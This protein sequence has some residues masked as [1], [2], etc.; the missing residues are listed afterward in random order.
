MYSGDTE[1]QHVHV[2]P[3]VVLGL[4]LSTSLEQ[5][6]M[7]DLELEWRVVA[8][9]PHSPRLEIVVPKRQPLEHRSARLIML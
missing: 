5:V 2:Y 8:A 7:V 3:W 4:S 9:L 1:L 6:V